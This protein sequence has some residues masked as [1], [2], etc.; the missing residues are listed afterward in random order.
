MHFIAAENLLPAAEGSAN[1]GREEIIC[2]ALLKNR[3]FFFSHQT[4]RLNSFILT[5]FSCSLSNVEK[6]TSTILPMASNTFSSPAFSALFELIPSHNARIAPS[7]KLKNSSK[8]QVQNC[9]IYSFNI[10]KKGARP[11]VSPNRLSE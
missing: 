3:M 7:N 2:K 6:I 1:C 11:I 8:M 10:T 4:D 9:G 5:D